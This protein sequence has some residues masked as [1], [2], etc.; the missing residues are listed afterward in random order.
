M[1]FLELAKERYSCRSFKDE[2]IEK[3]KII[4]YL[5]QQNFHL[6]LLTFNLKEY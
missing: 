6:L 2:K 4:K 3:E 5:R 1:D